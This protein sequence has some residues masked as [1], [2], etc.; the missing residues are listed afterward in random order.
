M[1]MFATFL[2]PLGEHIARFDVQLR[3]A[4][5]DRTSGEPTS[6]Y[7]DPKEIAW[8]HQPCRGSCDTQY[9]PGNA[10]QRDAC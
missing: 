4:P 5:P 2:G 7:C 8:Q 9:T 10:L 1:Q 3:A 6:P